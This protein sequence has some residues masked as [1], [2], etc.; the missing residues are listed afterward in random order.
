MAGC[1]VAIVQ[2]TDVQMYFQVVGGLQLRA[3]RMLDMEEAMQQDATLSERRPC[4]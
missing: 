1:Q 4:S 3:L 2:G